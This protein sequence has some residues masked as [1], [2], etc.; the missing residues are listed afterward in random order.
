MA[1][2]DQSEIMR[3]AVNMQYQGV[4][5]RFIALL[6]DSIILALLIGALGSILGFGLFSE[7]SGSGFGILSFII[8]LAYFTY[9][10]GSRGQTIGKMVT[11]IKVV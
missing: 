5:T 4:S 11:K 9:L 10:E 7:T 1:S 2:A 8:F 6:I 3:T